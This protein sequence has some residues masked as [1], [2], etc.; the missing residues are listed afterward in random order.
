MTP[1]REIIE[2]AERFDRNRD[3]YRSPSYNE[4]QLRRGFLASF[5]AA[6]GAA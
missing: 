3:A 1:P 5:F 2:L 4:T 6:L